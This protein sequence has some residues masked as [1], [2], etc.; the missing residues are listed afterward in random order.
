MT[1]P[2][3]READMTDQYIECATLCPLGHRG[4]QRIYGVIAD[5]LPGVRG[6]CGTCGEP[7]RLTALP[8]PTGRGGS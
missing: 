7:A 1:A 2:D 3:H 8:P 4:Y 5:D 6:R